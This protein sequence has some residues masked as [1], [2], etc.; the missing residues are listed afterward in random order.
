[1][2][3]GLTHWKEGE[4]KMPVRLPCTATW[5]RQ[6]VGS[7]EW[8]RA[9][10]SASSV[11]GVMC[12][13]QGC[14]CLSASLSEEPGKDNQRP[15]RSLHSQLCDPSLN[16]CGIRTFKENNILLMRCLGQLRVSEGGRC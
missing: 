2:G 12:S 14:S 8:E 10:G 6:E 7:G 13:G 9:L 15:L 1:M 3:W 5:G 4:A 11:M 16:K